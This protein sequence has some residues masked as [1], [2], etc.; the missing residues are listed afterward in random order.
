[1]ILAVYGS[2]KTCKGVVLGENGEKNIAINKDAADTAKFMFWD[3]MVPVMN[4][5]EVK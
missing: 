3:D 1:M 4:A 2:D 5:V